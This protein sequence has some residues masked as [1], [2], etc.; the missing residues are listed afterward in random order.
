[1]DF[2]SVSGKLLYRACVKV[3]NKK[4]LSGRDGEGT[5]VARAQLLAGD[6]E[7]DVSSGEPD[8][9]IW[10]IERCITAADIRLN[11]LMSDCPLQ[12]DVR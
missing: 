2:G 3:L 1:M 7:V 11:L 5:N 8:L 6:P 4:K 10:M 9:V 12:M